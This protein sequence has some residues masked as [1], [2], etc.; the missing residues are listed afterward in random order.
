MQATVPSTVF[1]PLHAVDLAR[2]NRI[3]KLSETDRSLATANEAVAPG[4]MRGTTAGDPADLAGS[5]LAQLTRRADVWHVNGTAVT[6]RRQNRR[7]GG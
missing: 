7:S 1:D 4:G 5:A 2:A 3:A 6:R